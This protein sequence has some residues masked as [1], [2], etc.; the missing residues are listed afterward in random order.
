MT[1]SVWMTFATF[2]KSNG[3]SASMWENGCTSDEAN[4][5]CHALTHW[6]QSEWELPGEFLLLWTRRDGIAFQGD[7]ELVYAEDGLAYLLPNPFLEGDPEGFITM[8]QTI[9]AGDRS[10]LFSVSLQSRL[11][12]NAV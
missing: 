12:Y 4:A 6:L 5:V 7:H 3:F 1:K 2:L 10:T 8:L 11:L 9:L